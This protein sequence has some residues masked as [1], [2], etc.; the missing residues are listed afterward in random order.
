MQ[1]RSRF[2]GL[3][4]VSDGFFGLAMLVG[5]L[6]VLQC[7]CMKAFRSQN[8]ITL[9][10]VILVFFIVLL[11]ISTVATPFKNLAAIAGC[12]LVPEECAFRDK[13]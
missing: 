7:L 1:Q 4:N 9:V 3:R 2:Q 6:W 5:P 8:R 11:S 12:F 10:A 13:K